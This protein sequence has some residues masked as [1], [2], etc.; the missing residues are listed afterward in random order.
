M[1]AILELF[2]W[3]SK[4]VSLAAVGAMSII[5]INCLGKLKLL[6]L[7]KYNLCFIKSEIF[8]KIFRK[9]HVN[10]LCSDENMS[11]KFTDGCSIK[12]S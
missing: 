3:V 6:L 2:G 4:A 10:L 1:G 11:S 9:N 7:L 12:V 8:I 5:H